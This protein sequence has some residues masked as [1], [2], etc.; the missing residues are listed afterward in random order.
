VATTVLAESTPVIV[1]PSTEQSWQYFAE[2]YDFPLLQDGLAN[3]NAPLSRREYVINIVPA[4]DR[5]LDLQ[6]QGNRILENRCR[7]T[8]RA[9]T[10]LEDWV[11]Y[12]QHVVDRFDQNKQTAPPQLTSQQV[13]SQQAQVSFSPDIPP[14]VPADASYVDSLQLLVELWQFEDSLLR[15]DGNFQG[16]QPLTRGEFMR[17]LSQALTTLD[18]LTARDQFLETL[19]L[20][21]HDLER[22]LIQVGQIRQQI[23]ALHELTGSPNHLAKAGG[24]MP[25]AW[26]VYIDQV[27]DVS[28]DDPVY[29]TLQRMIEEYGVDDVIQGEGYFYPDAALTR[30]DFVMSFLGMLDVL[31]MFPGPCDYF[32]SGPTRQVEIVGERIEALETHLDRLLN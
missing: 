26:G 32:V 22:L 11:T 31:V 6:S 19:S 17:Y 24:Q 4:L 14:D 3:L 21:N 27:V 7:T 30:G 9:I 8:Y 10:Y 16:D 13:K 25:L 15:A 5:Y 2:D 20:A 29:D 23:E 28:P 18:E 12:W 1:S